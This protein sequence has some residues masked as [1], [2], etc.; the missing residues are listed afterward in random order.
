L[1][2]LQKLLALSLDR[3][4]ASE[5]LPVTVG[6]W[7]EAI[8]KGREFERDLDAPRFRTA[9]VTLAESRTTWPAPRDFLAALP[10][11]QQLRLAK[12]AI[13]ADPARA[14]AAIAEANRM[15]GRKT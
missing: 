7:C 6:A 13:P 10:D 5:L 1:K 8:R 14:E 15:L 3:T 4:P 2:G 11:R 12:T 9:F